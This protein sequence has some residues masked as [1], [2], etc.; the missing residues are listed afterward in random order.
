[1]NPNPWMACESNY[2]CYVNTCILDEKK[3]KKRSF[4]GSNWK[5]I[6]R[7]HLDLCDELRNNII[8]LKS[9]LVLLH[10]NIEEVK[11]N[12]SYFKQYHIDTQVKRVYK[13]VYDIKENGP[14]HFLFDEEKLNRLLK[15]L[16]ECF[17]LLESEVQGYVEL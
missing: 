10:E 13:N 5:T 3:T 2:W 4:R 8:Y 6:L 1:M 9:G 11:A 7:E 16:R 12:K 14:F 17:L 15:S